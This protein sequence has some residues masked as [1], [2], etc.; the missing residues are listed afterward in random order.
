M[1]SVYG[2]NAHPDTSNK[3]AA[4]LGPQIFTRLGSFAFTVG[5]EVSNAIAVQIQAKD[6]RGRNLNRRAVIC[7]IVSSSSFGIGDA[8]FT[9]V[10][11]TTGVLVHES[12]TETV[13]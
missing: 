11:I 6:I 7:V 13:L 2:P 3:I 8:S 10:D 4:R 1:A 12:P 9:D 5:A